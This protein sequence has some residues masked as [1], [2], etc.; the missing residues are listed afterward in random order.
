M[1][2][3][4]ARAFSPRPASQNCLFAVFYSSFRE[5]VEMID[6]AAG[7]SC[8]VAA[9]ANSPAKTERESGKFGS[10]QQLERAI[11]AAKQLLCAAPTREQ[12]LTH[13]RE[14]VRLI[15]QRTPARVRFMERTRGLA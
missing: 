7:N 4:F 12:K 5:G 14:M 15:D 3:I 8:P 2:H 6:T 11:E 1:P 9:S 10:E 13:W